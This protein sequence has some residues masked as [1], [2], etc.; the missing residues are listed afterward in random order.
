MFPTV[1][2]HPQQRNTSAIHNW[3]AIQNETTF[4]SNIRETSIETGAI[5]R[6]TINPNILLRPYFTPSSRPSHHTEDTPAVATRPAQPHQPNR[7]KFPPTTDNNSPAHT[8]LQ[9]APTPHRLQHNQITK[10]VGSQ[11]T[12]R[13]LRSASC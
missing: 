2:D 5:T 6:R 7:H 12:D 9:G 8:L 1:K 10:H 13:G 4:I 3:L 11:V